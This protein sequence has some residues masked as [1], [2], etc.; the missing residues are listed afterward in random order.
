MNGQSGSGADLPMP[1]LGVVLLVLLLVM[2][3]CSTM[4]KTIM[5][6]YCAN[7]SVSHTCIMFS[8]NSHSTTENQVAQL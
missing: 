2:S 1:M 3:G 7:T 6:Q 4:T 8:K 5:Y